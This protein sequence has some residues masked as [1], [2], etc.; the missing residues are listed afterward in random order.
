MK[1]LPL[2]ARVQFQR[3]SSRWPALWLPIGLA[4]P[5]VLLLC[6][7]LLVLGYVF[8]QLARGYSSARYLELCA[9]LYALLC[10]ARGT[11]VDVRGP[12]AAISVSIR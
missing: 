3:E 5:I 7:P 11:Q 12:H 4:W 2:F 8:A 1:I 10:A 9:S 6:A